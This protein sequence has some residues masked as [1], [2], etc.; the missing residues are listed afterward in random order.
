MVPLTTPDA[1]PLTATTSPSE[2]PLATTLLESVTNLDADVIAV[3]AQ[4]L[5][6]GARNTSHD[7]PTALGTGPR[8]GAK[9]HAL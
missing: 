4:A 2:N 8:C 6:G 9:H 5:S 3:P 1:P 7:G